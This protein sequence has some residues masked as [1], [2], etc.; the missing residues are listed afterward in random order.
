MCPES[1]PKPN[2]STG[3]RTEAG[4][5]ASSQNALR[6]GLASG[7]IIVPG[8]DPEAFQSLAASLKK[9]YAPANTMEEL[10]VADMARHHWL[11]D[12]AMRLQDEGIAN[13]PAG[14]LPA[15]FAV[16]LRYQ[17]TNERAFHK[18]LATLTTLQ[19]QRKSDHREFVSQYE[20][21]IGSTAR[22]QQKAIAS[23]Y[24]KSSDFPP[25][26]TFEEFVARKFMPPSLL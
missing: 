8:E 19:K 4:K 22:H 12:R 15:N 25:L 18:A 20:E 2:A 7:T 16:L 5:A 24:R 21:Q 14:E 23:G 9:L 26:P 6:H 11:K 3:P 10:L 13:A 1:E 17:A